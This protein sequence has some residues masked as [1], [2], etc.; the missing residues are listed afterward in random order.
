MLKVNG[1][2]KIAEVFK[3]DITDEL[4]MKVSTSCD[5][6]DTE[7]TER[8]YLYMV[9]LRTGRMTEFKPGKNII[10]NVG[11]LFTTLSENMATVV[12]EDVDENI[13]ILPAR[14]NN[15]GAPLKS[16]NEKEEEVPDE[17]LMKHISDSQKKLEEVE[18]K[19]DLHPPDDSDKNDDPDEDE[20]VD[21]EEDE[22]DNPFA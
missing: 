13:V 15:I 16:G 20:E 22:D 11:Q 7:E 5:I 2:V 9:V 18:G 3:A 6:G 19:M 4:H 14:Y 1:L 12:V 10:I 21:N 8:N 17:D